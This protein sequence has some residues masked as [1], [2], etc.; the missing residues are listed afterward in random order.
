MIFTRI[1]ITAR[2]NYQKSSVLVLLPG[3]YIHVYIYMLNAYTSHI[4]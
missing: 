3:V 1:K 4:S 2:N